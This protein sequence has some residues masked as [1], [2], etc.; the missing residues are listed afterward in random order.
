MSSPRLSI[1]NQMKLAW[2][3]LALIA[4]DGPISET[5]IA[6][7]LRIHRPRAWR[8]VKTMRQAGMPLEAIPDPAW[9]GPAQAVEDLRDHPMGGCLTQATPE[10]MRILTP[11]SAYSSRY[12]TLPTPAWMMNPA[13]RMQGECVT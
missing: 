12:T 10:S 1:S 11:E 6:K 3:I 9:N 2:Q 8:M 13:H 4:Q 5:E 7:R